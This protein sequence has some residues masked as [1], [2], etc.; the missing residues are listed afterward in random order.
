MF[1]STAG[2]IGG[3]PEEGWILGLGIQFTLGQHL[4]ARGHTDV[5]DDCGMF[6]NFYECQKEKN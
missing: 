4:D 5:Y 1:V 2:S 6:A 3:V